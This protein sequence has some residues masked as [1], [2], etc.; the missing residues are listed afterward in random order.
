VAPDLT[1]ERGDDGLSSPKDLAGGIVSSSTLAAVAFGLVGGWIADGVTGVWEPALQRVLV[2]GCGA[3][4]VLVGCSSSRGGGV[5]RAIIAAAAL[6]WILMTASSLAHVRVFGVAVLLAGLALANRG[7]GGVVFSLAARA[8][9]VLGVF[10]FART[11]IPEVWL[12]ADAVG[13][14]VG[15]AAGWLV[16]GE[17][18]VG[19]TFGGVDYLVAVGALC[20]GWVMVQPAPRWRRGVYAGAM[21]LGGHLVFLVVLAFSADLRDALPASVPGVPDPRLPRSLTSSD[22]WWLHP[23]RAAVPWNLPLLGAA[24][25]AGI[26]AVLLRRTPAFDSGDRASEAGRVRSGSSRVVWGVEA[27]WKVGV[28][29]LAVLLPALGSLWLTPLTLEGKRVVLY[30]KGYVDWNKPEHGHYGFN[31]R[32]KYGLLLELLAALGARPVVSEDLADPDL[33]GAD[34]VVLIHPIA[35]WTGDQL[36]R[37][38]GYVEQGGSLLLL[39]EHTTRDRDGSSRFN[40]VLRP[41]R[42]RVPFDSAIM[43]VSGWRHSYERLAHPGIAALGGDRNR[44]GIT[45][46]ASVMARWPASPLLAGTW[47]WNDIGDV[48]HGGQRAMLGDW[49]YNTGERLGDVL[50][51]GEQKIGRGRIVVF[52]DTTGF[53]NG[54]CERSHV[55]ISRLLADLAARGGKARATWRRWGS[56]ACAGL[57][58]AMLVRRRSAAEVVLVA[59]GMSLSAL[60]CAHLSEERVARLLP[61]GTRQTPNNLAYIDATHLDRYSDELWAQEGLAGLRQTLNR[62]GYLALEL[63]AFTRARLLRAGV[64]ISIAPAR[65]FSVP[66]RQLVREFVEQ[67]GVFIS[68][69]GYEERQ[70]SATLWA[71]LGFGWGASSTNRPNAREP[72]PLG[73]TSAPYL[74]AG[75]YLCQ[76]DFRAA[77]PVAV[78]AEEAHV[79]AR[80]VDG[81]PIAAWRRIG[82]GKVLVIGDSGFALNQNLERRDGGPIEGQRRNAHFWRWLITVLRDE[83]AWIPIEDAPGPKPGAPVRRPRSGGGALPAPRA[84]PAAGA[85]P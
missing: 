52:G 79:I 23:A 77:W 74:D 15:R 67:G 60:A 45:V 2:W 41:T 40:E 32:G 17:L 19:A 73:H 48:G 21:I 18:W 29:G 64:L 42:L 20:T 36:E 31:A 59:L 38:W 76:M 65:A 37:L 33:A 80:G 46:G 81:L 62:N 71:E 47:G 49:R 1:M 82:K 83:P 35:P 56:I 4:L 58:V 70:P 51:A 12:L 72:Q 27:G 5:R 50:L 44:V 43:A 39:G 53:Y 13:A 22:S 9:A 54:V 8:L 30:G 57:L 68:T 28:V 16:G 63:P 25:H 10:R 26:A 55:F 69:V 66:D 24:I 84:V 61:D 75:G 3:A 14:H 78:I 34:V 6:I 85:Q 11:S 7:A